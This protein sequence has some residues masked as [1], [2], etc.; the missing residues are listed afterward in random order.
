MPC[1][2]GIAMSASFFIT[3]SSP[4]L[5]RTGVGRRRSRRDGAFAGDRPAVAPGR[6]GRC[7]AA[8]ARTHWACS[9]NPT[10]AGYAG[11]SWGT[12]G[13]ARLPR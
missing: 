8:P 1:E 3:M 6:P 11:A 4:T 10:P 5:H 12:G 7:S 13:V 2:P 9:L